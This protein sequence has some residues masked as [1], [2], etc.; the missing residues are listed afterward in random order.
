MGDHHGGGVHFAGKFR[1][2][3]HDFLGQGGVKGGGGL[4]GKQK[5][6]LGHQG[7]RDIDTLAL[8]TGKLRHAATAQVG[9]TD[10]LEQLIST[11]RAHAHPADVVHNQQLFAHRQRCQEVCLLENHADILTAHLG[12]GL[13]IRA[14]EIDAGDFYA[15]RS[16]S[17]QAS[18]NGEQGGFTG[19]GFTD[20]GGQLARLGG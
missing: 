1:N 5:R 8:T 9:Q 3:R 17:D 10:L 6:W 7:A 18:S 20:N 12:T 13:I 2:Q 14:G 4:I 11:L 15:A 19:A 16:R